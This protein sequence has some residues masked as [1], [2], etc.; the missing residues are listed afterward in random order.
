VEF[1]KGFQELE[2]PVKKMKGEVKER[3]ER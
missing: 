1:V 3:R 2:I